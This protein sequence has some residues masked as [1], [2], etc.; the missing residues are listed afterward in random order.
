MAFRPQYLRHRPRACF[1]CALTL[2]AAKAGACGADYGSCVRSQ[3]CE[4][5][6]YTCFAKN[7]QY[8]KCMPS[9]EPGIHKDDKP[10]WNTE[11]SCKILPE[12]NSSWGPCTEEG[13]LLPKKLG[14]PQYGAATIFCWALAAPGTHEPELIVTQ[15]KQG[16]GIFGCDGYT[17]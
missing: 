5:H 8:A 10:P 3:C 2:L 9:C 16:S 11:W 13:R 17:L 15:W 1:L 12:V 7:E 4:N 6:H 14:A